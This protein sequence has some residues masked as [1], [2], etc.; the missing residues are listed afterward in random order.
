MEAVVD[1]AAK[2]FVGDGGDGDGGQ[3]VGL[4][5]AV[6]PAEAFEEAGGGFGEVAGGA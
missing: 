6:Q 4:G 3:T 1:G 2:V 5:F